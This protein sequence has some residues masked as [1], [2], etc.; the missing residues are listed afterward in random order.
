MQI[1]T[2]YHLL[3]VLP[4]KKGT[5]IGVAPE[6]REIR[7]ILG[8][9]E[10]KTGGR[11]LAIEFPSPLTGGGKRCLAIAN[12]VC[13]AGL[14]SCQRDELLGGPILPEGDPFLIDPAGLG[15]AA[16]VAK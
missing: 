14:L 6:P 1:P 11:P 5:E 2:L 4:I 16:T 12:Q 10:F 7:E 9:G 13:P 15:F 3:K 8:E